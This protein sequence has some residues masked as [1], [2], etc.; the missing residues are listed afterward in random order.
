MGTAFVQDKREELATPWEAVT[1]HGGADHRHLR[2]SLH[3]L[4]SAWKQVAQVGTS[5]QRQQAAVVLDD[6]R[7]A[8]YRILAGDDQTR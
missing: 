7:R 8:M 3:G 2:D 4:V 6:A 5:E 1:E